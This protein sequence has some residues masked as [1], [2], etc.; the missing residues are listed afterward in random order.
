M[1]RFTFDDGRVSVPEPGA[2][3]L[4]GVGALLMLT[5]RRRNSNR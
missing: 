4:F 3:A 5:A 1:S 2:L